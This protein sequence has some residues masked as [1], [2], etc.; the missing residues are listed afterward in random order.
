MPDQIKWGYKLK[1][2]QTCTEHEPCE[3]CNDL[4]EFSAR[5]TSCGMCYPIFDL[6]MVGEEKKTP[7]MFE[8]KEYAI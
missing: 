6:V 7:C 1:R 2:M 5:P 3:H 8:R 4:R